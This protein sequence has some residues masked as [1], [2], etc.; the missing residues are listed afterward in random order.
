MALPLSARPTHQQRQPW[1]NNRADGARGAPRRLAMKPALGTLPPAAVYRLRQ[2]ESLAA[3]RATSP[4][5][6]DIWASSQKRI[7]DQFLK[8]GGITMKVI[9]AAYAIEPSLR[10]N[11]QPISASSS[12][13]RSRSSSSLS[14]SLCRRGTRTASI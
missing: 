4:D 5:T 12:G 14:A 1:H 7:A 13:A 8:R 6:C 3:A 2:T 11:V 9:L 10:A